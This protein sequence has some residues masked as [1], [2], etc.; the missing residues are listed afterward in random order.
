MIESAVYSVESQ[1]ARLGVALT[2]SVAPET[3]DVERLLLDTAVALPENARLLPLCVTWLAHFGGIVAR[4][5]L[6]RLIE[7]SPEQEAQGA[8][9]LLLDEAVLNGASNEFL[10]PASLCAPLADARPLYGFQQSAP[11]VEIAE[12][13]ASA[14]SRKWGV[15]APPVVV[16][17][18]ALRPVSWV[19]EHNPSLRDRIIRKG[20]LR[21]SLLETLRRDCGG[22]V[23]SESELTRLS[24]ATRTAVRKALAALVLEG[25]VVVGPEAG[26]KRDH[27]VR[28]T[29]A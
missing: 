9:G 2:G 25:E 26:S 29:A 11:L 18:D 12:R 4:H 7:E 23:A 14:L 24:G 13:N 28:L 1:W 16:K 19:L 5:R 3:P 20:D 6:C 8:L 27:P 10:V 15:W 22:W 21:C 17:P